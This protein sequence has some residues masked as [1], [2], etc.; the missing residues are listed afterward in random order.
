MENS[1][2]KFGAQERM[3]E[4]VAVVVVD[5]ERVLLVKH[6]RNAEHPTGIYGLPAGRLE[7]GEEPEHAAKRELTQETGIV[8]QKITRLPT[9]YIAKLERKDGQPKVFHMISYKCLGFDGELKS[10]DETVP[11]W[12]NLANLSSIDLLPNVA[13]VIKEAQDLIE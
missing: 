7:P 6:V 10:S 13:D 12:I 1:D 3:I 8:A 5:N 11:E 2:G 4:T 9:E